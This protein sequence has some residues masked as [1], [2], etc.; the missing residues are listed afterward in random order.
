MRRLVRA[1]WIA[2]ALIWAAVFGAIMLGER[3]LRIRGR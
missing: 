3:L 1:L 2:A